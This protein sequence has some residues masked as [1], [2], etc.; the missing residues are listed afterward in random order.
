L[1]EAHE[2]HVSKLLGSGEAKKLRSLLEQ[3]NLKLAA[4]PPP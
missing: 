1:S 2:Q 3:L 4:S